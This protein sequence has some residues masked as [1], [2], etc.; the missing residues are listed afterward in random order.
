MPASPEP[1]KSKMTSISLRRLFVRN[2]LCASLIAIGL[3]ACSGSVEKSEPQPSE[4]ALSEAEA[5]QSITEGRVLAAV[6]IYTRLADEA[7][8]Q[9][10]KQDFELKA[11]EALF[12]GGYPELA[13]DRLG[14]LSRPSLTPTLAIRRRIVEARAAIEF[15][16]PQQAIDALPADT[17]E[18]PLAL[19][20]RAE[21]ARAQAHEALGD[22]E[23]ALLTRIKL[24]QWLTGPDSV[25][26]NH[27][28]IWHMLENLPDI[29][30]A[31]LEGFGRGATYQG[32][33]ELSQIVDN[34]R[35]GTGNLDE[36]LPRWLQKFPNH[37]AADQFAVSLIEEKEVAPIIERDQI[38]LLLPM[39][40]KLSE[41]AIAVRDGFFA[42]YFTHDA[43]QRPTVRIYDTAA[44]C[45][46]VAQLYSQAVNDGALA[47]VGPLSKDRV[48]ELASLPALPVPTL[49]LN[50]ANVTPTS[51]L[52]D[53]LYQFGLLPEDEARAAAEF[54]VSQGYLR[55]VALTSDSAWGTRLLAAFNQRL[56]ELGGTL[57]DHQSFSSGSH[58]FSK[59]IRRLLNLDRS[60]SRKTILQSILGT[61]LEFEPHRRQDVDFLFLAANAKLAR[62]IKPQLKFHRGG[63]IPVF[64]T[65]R[66]FSGTRNTR[67]DADMESIYIC[68]IPW[69]LDD[70]TRGSRLF[71]HVNALWPQ[72]GSLARLYAMGIDAYP[73]ISQIQFLALDPEFSYPGRTGELRLSNQ[74]R[75]QR[76]LSW[77]QFVDGVPVPVRKPNDDL[78]ESTSLQSG[79]G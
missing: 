13:I 25:Q 12:D 31:A 10:D 75:I 57:L 78:A 7:R 45:A 11:I 24:E 27:K 69:F 18:L 70:T 65:S 62:Q 60:Q 67:K 51:L 79:D 44:S 56:V 29:D 58:D 52:P 15:S 14:Q 32:W 63:D 28:K 59:P 53:N 34:A 26:L 73:L 8:D 43:A 30:R 20:A 3:L 2:S 36:V 64:A 17:T 55:A 33:I 6:R 46:S 5:Q 39:S 47:V 21:E 71:Q 19:R 41:L 48:N 22:I 37:P 61:E 50:Y 42:S 9:G 35:R 54:A 38:A 49:A 23:N 74:N 4:P 72:Q 68:D 40:G 76:T 16:E 77:A 66:A 1:D